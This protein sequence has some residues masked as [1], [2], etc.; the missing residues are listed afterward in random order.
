MKKNHKKKMKILTKSELENTINR[1]HDFYPR[2]HDPKWDI[3]TPVNHR[4]LFC[5]G[6]MVAHWFAAFEA[7]QLFEAITLCE[8]S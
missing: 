8:L 3:Q 6:V 1:E 7:P 5:V 2:E 4:A